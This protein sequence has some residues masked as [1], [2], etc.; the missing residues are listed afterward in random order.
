[1]TNENRLEK[2]HSQIV[3]EDRVE[4]I[5]SNVEI[6]ENIS[7]WGDGGS[8]SSTPSLEKESV[9]SLCAHKLSSIS[10]IVEVKT[11]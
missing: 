2:F 5:S 4:I 11:G 3:K 10:E 7:K 6:K 9:I 8:V 1:V